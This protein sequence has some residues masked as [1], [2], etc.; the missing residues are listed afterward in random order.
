MMVAWRH[1]HVGHLRAECL[2]VRGEKNTKRLKHHQH[3][4]TI[5]NW[6]PILRQR[7]I[8][9]NM[10]VG[11]VSASH[12]TSSTY[13]P[14]TRHLAYSTKP[15]WLSLAQPT[16]WGT[17]C[18]TWSFL[19]SLR[20][21]VCK[22]CLSTTP[23]EQIE[24]LFPNHFQKNQFYLHSTSHFYL[25]QQIGRQNCFVIGFDFPFWRYSTVKLSFRGCRPGV[26]K[27]A[28]YNYGITMV[29]KATTWDGS[30]P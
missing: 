6:Y 21:V 22:S 15:A 3:K 18:I 2:T 30:S 26:S 25:Q 29:I 10:F 17:L 5:K 19:D 9:S 16:N 23:P 28:G 20:K 27:I 8:E 24:Q 1:D 11:F 12:S 14:L 7:H 4:L 13:H